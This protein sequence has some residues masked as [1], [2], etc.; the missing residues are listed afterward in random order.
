MR[1]ISNTETKKTTSREKRRKDIKAGV[2]YD[3]RTAVLCLAVFLWCT[4][5]YW[6][7]ISEM[8]ISADGECF[9]S[10]GNG[11]GRE[12]LGRSEGRGSRGQTIS[13]TSTPFTPFEKSIKLNWVFSVWFPHRWR[14]HQLWTSAACCCLLN[15][16]NYCRPR[17]WWKRTWGFRCKTW[18]WPLLKGS[19]HIEAT[20]QIENRWF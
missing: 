6:W 11:R 20:E 3:L 7:T 19:Q 14:F 4:W 15:V 18:R 13:S 9:N 2:Y 10:G 8:F 5:L 12:G 1:S 16:W 17:S